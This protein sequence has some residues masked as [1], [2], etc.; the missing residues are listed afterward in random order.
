[1]TKKT[2]EYAKKFI[3]RIPPQAWDR[4]SKNTELNLSFLSGSDDTKVMSYIVKNNLAEP[5]NLAKFLVTFQLEQIKAISEEFDC[6]R[7]D[8][9]ADW[10]SKLKSAETKFNFAQSIPVDQERRNQV[11][12][13]IN[14]VIECTRV[15]ADDVQ[16]HINSI[17]S[18]DNQS[19]REFFFKSII[20]LKRC[21]KEMEFAIA[22][23]SLFQESF[24]LLFMFCATEG[25]DT[26]AFQKDYDRDVRNILSDDNCLLMA[27]YCKDASEKEFWH[28][29]SEQLEN[30]I[31]TILEGRE[32]F[33]EKTEDSVS[34]FWDED[35]EIIDIERIF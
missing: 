33:N 6:L 28:G 21:K 27:K 26:S 17:R 31:N 19:P 1:M 13:A 18:I 4:L 20:S 15:F 8:R 35:D 9:N 5:N 7:E 3:K 10:R 29:L 30:N 25:Y 24:K 14:D 12:A 2:I 11:M 23:V 32:V 22:K 34:S 16:R